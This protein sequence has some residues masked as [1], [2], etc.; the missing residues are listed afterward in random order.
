MVSYFIERKAKDHDSNKDYKNVSS[1]AFGLFR[2]GHIQKIELA[3]DNEKV[4]FKCNCLPEMKKD[5][6]Y[7]LKL[8]MGKN[9][10]CN[11]EIFYSSCPC[12]TGKGP[13]GSCSLML[14]T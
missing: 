9:G 4:N 13:L 6:V 7:K 10:N 1:K 2:H 14:C 5:S 12:P 11:G 8:S 3:F